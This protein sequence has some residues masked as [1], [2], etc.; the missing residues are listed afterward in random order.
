MYM[1]ITSPK[2]ALDSLKLTKREDGKF[3]DLEANYKNYTVKGIIEL[4]CFRIDLKEGIFPYL[5][6]EAFG[7]ISF[8][9]LQNGDDV[10]IT[11]EMKNIEGD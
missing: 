3:Y 10:L 2:E 5:S 1:A 6:N 4:N 9:F 7:F 11:K 8:N